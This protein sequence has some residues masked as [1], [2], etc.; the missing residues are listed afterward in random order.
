VRRTSF[1]A[2][3]GSGERWYVESFDINAVADL[4]RP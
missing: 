4:C 2:V 1:V 3:P